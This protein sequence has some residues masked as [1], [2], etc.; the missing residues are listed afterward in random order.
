MN[1]RL[2]TSSLMGLLLGTVL[3]GCATSPSILTPHT[4]ASLQ[5]ASLT[6]LMFAIG[7][8]VFI[9]VIILLSLVFRRSQ[10]ERNEQELYT[11]D[12]STLRNVVLGGG[13]IP[14]VVLLIVM[15]LGIRIEQTAN[16]PNPIGV[17]NIEIEVIGHQWWWEIRYANQ[18]FSTANEIHIPA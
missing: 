7:S 9:I 12:R 3:T 1:I 4:T 2:V 10:T 11:H 17:S 14:I 16:D 5:T 6:W 18:N 15:G 13:I 8:V